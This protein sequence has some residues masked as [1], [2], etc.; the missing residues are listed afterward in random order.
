MLQKSVLFLLAFC[1]ILNAQEKKP[2]PN[3]S[4][5]SLQDQ[6]DKISER[7]TTILIRLTDI[8]NSLEKKLETLLNHILKSRDSHETGTL[9]IRNKKKIIGDLQKAQATYKKYRD[10]IDVIFKNDAKL[11]QNDINNLKILM[12]EKINNRIKQI[13]KI[14]DSLAAYK[15][16]YDAWNNQY[17]DRRNV[18]MADREKNRIM[19]DFEKEIAELNEKAKKINLS[20]TYSDPQEKIIKRYHDIQSI[21]ERI[22]LL[23]H[24]IEDIRNGGNDGKKIGKIEGFRLDKEVRTLSTKAGVEL[25]SFF[26]ALNAYQNNLFQRKALLANQEKLKPKKQP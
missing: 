5:G 10:N 1:F 23:E 15:E 3:K 16:Y 6:I 7:E 4:L 17:N 13:T 26:F 2:E 21:N 24:S 20:S 12:D 9:V 8:D 19:K 14:T 25:K 22:S 11:I 18:Q